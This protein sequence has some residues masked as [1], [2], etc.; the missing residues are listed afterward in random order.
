IVMPVYGEVETGAVRVVPNVIEFR[1]PR[2]KEGENVKVMLQ[3]LVPSDDDRVELVRVEPSFLQAEPPKM[4][5]KGL[6][7]MAVRI[8]RENPEAEKRQPD[9]FFEGQLV[10]KTSAPAAPDV[11]VR[12][13][14]QPA[15]K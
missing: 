8:P 5:R 1:T 13:K 6:W 2:L 15:G 12:I 7:Q 4:V 9:N 11:P 10:L 14:W 3:F